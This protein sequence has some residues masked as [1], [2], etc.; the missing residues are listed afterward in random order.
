[1]SVLK[2]QKKNPWTR[3][4]H[5]SEYHQ[6]TSPFLEIIV[7][8][9][10]DSHVSF[11][12]YRKQAWNATFQNA[13]LYSACCF[14]LPGCLRSR[15]K[16][17]PKFHEES[18]PCRHPENRAEVCSLCHGGRSDGLKT[19]SQKLIRWSNKADSTRKQHYASLVIDLPISGASKIEI[20]CQ[21]HRLFIL[22]A[23]R[24]LATGVKLLH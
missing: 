3:V 16:P 4:L 14:A 13:R 24:R 10:R 7:N 18:F 2:S 9:F 1:M 5:A 22:T 11:M 15:E 8:N 17:S 19:H 6:T 23:S 12:E 20:R 21:D